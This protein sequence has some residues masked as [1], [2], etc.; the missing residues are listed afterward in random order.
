[1][2]VTLVETKLFIASTRRSIYSYRV[3]FLGSL[4][5]QCQGTQLAFTIPDLQGCKGL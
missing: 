4:Q 5:T 2:F 3:Q 1:M